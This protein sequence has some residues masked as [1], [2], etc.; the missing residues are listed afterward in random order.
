MECWKIE[1]DELRFVKEMQF[2]GISNIDDKLAPVLLPLS[3][4]NESKFKSVLKKVDIILR[5]LKS[6]HLITKNLE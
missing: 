2:Y 6:I 4:S 1:N 5:K 3:N